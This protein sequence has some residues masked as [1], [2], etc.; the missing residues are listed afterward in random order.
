MRL[1]GYEICGQ[2][3]PS[4]VIPPS[5]LKTVC[6]YYDRNNFSRAHTPYIDNVNQ[7]NNNNYYIRV[8]LLGSSTLNIVINAVVLYVVYLIKRLSEKTYWY[9]VA[10]LKIINK[11]KVAC[12]KII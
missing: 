8:F 1:G 12:Y 9:R 3:Y 2:Y 4:Q 7:N 6:R 5:E 11:D 10:Y